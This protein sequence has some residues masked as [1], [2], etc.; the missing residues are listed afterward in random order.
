MVDLLEENSILVGHHGSAQIGAPPPV[1]NQIQK[2]LERKSGRCLLSLS[3][4]LTHDAHRLVHG[5]A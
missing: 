2:G 4:S 5:S 3:L 1:N